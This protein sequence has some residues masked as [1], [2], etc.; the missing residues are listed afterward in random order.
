ML[1]EFKVAAEFK[2]P[3]LTELLP[4]LP[5]VPADVAVE[6][7]WTGSKQD[8]L[9][10]EKAK[11]RKIVLVV[12]D[13]ETQERTLW[14]LGGALPIKPEE[15]EAARRDLGTPALNV[16]WRVRLMELG[17]SRGTMLLC[18]IM[19]NGILAG[20]KSRPETVAIARECL[21]SRL[22][23]TDADVLMRLQVARR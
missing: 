9:A 13:T 6:A 2:G 11:D 21:L 7:R 8:Y 12:P 20:R 5:D 14:N 17:H 15:L 10:L 1:P 18:K 4:I 3:T 23:P 19:S 16:N 22:D